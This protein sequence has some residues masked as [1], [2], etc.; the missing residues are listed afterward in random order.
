MSCVLRVS[1]KTF[2]SR[3]Y[4]ARTTLPVIRAYARGEAREAGP[5]T[6]RKHSASGV[7]VEVSR[8]DAANLTRQIRDAIAFLERHRRALSRLRRTSGVEEITLDFGIAA[9]DAA[10]QFDYFPPELL[11]AAGRLGIGLEVSRYDTADG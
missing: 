5:V 8:A 7:D 1:G 3:S 9:R 4:A 11:L 6:G 2:A 10:A